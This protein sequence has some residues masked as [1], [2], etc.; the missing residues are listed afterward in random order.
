M[1]FSA[2]LLG[3]A[4]ILAAG[5]AVAAIGGVAPLTWPI[6]AALLAAL[7][8]FNT[9]LAW[10][11]RRRWGK[12]TARAR[13]RSLLWFA[14]SLWYW[15]AA[16]LVFWMVMNVNDRQLAWAALA[17]IW[18]V[19]IIGGGLF[20][21]A[22]ETLFRPLANYLD[23]GRRAIAPAK[24]YRLAM[25]YPL[26]A[27]YVLFSVAI[28]GYGAGTAQIAWFAD[29]PVVEQAKGMLQGL[30]VTLYLC[31]ILYAL[32]DRY[33]G[34]A[35]RQLRQDFPETKYR[36]RSLRWRIVGLTSAVI[37]SGVGLV[38]LNIFRT[39]QPALTGQMLLRDIVRSPEMYRLGGGIALSLI[40]T[41]SL[42]FFVAHVI[43]R[44]LRSLALLAQVGQ[45]RDEDYNVLR[46]GDEV[47]VVADAFATRVKD[48]SEQRNQYRESTVRKEA[49]FDSMGEGLVLTDN[50]GKVV[51]MNAQAEELLGWKLAEAQEREWTSMIRIGNAEGQ[52]L[53][54]AESPLT[55]VLLQGERVRSDAFTVQR[56]NGERFPVALTAALCEVDGKRIG[57]V[58]VFQDITREKA[59]DKA[60]TEFVSLAS[61]QLRTPLTA[62]NWYVELLKKAKGLTAEGRQDVR[63][64][65][66]RSQ[67]MVRLVNDLLNVSRLD[68]GQMR[69]N[70]VP[71]DL[72]AL[73]Q[74]VIDDLIPLAQ[75]RDCRI[76]FHKSDES[77]EDVALDP[78]LLGQVIHNLVENAIAY[79]RPGPD[80]HVWVQLER[81]GGG[82]WMISVQD[83]GIGIPEENQDRVF[84]KFFR[85]DNAMRK[86]TEG[87]GLGLY[88][89][90]MILNQAR[91]KIWFESAEGRGTTFFVEIPAEGM[92]GKSGLDLTAAKAD[93]GTYEQRESRHY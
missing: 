43:T 79:S 70:P 59:I 91:G 1:K 74:G 58:V 93:T 39:I 26:Q 31:V 30:A 83:N 85:S 14:M 48:L 32:L 36:W 65:S 44:A 18:E 5:Y 90:K 45:A 61:H 11:A 50:M 69:I 63:K 29:W 56:K 68:T 27:A 52:R 23:L 33:L 4:I 47:E 15:T 25:K 17:F 57:A 71:T 24:M 88:L 55:R 76:I 2:A 81:G 8:G 87:T 7:T 16:P 40:F 19:P 84:A 66:Q 38:G 67:G 34:N 62:I 82:S 28:V 12:L 41:L 86:E 53:L 73:I 21:L 13:V 64:I 6:F 92:R 3:A 89:A 9:L 80:S 42:T 60:K 49:I 75:A 72:A 78:A 35:R 51:S 10:S 20:V 54:P 37:V 77:Y 46:T 22:A